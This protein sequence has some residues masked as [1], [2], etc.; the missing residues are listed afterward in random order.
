MEPTKEELLIVSEDTI[1]SKIYTIR[2]QKVM[3][4]ADLAEIYGYTTKA[5]NQQVKNNIEKFEA[6]FRF[7]LSDEETNNVSRSKNLTLNTTIGRGQNIKYNPYAFTEQGIYMLMTVLKGELA[8]KQSKSLIRIFKRM[9]DFLTD[10]QYLI[11]NEELLRLSLQTAQNTTDIALL[12]ENMIARS[13]LSKIM[14]NFNDPSIR[15][16]YLIYNGKTVEVTLAYQQIY[17][18][19]K[20]TV[21]IVDNYIGLKTLLPL[22]EV[23]AGV[24]CIVFSDN[25]QKGL[26]KAEYDDFVIEY[27]IISLSFHKTC[28]Q[29]HDRYIIIDYKTKSER[30]F[31][32]GTSS[33]DAGKR[34]TTI[35]QITDNLI[36]HPLIVTLLKILLL[37]YL[38]IIR[39]I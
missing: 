10:N 18:L 21:Y 27:P 28:N 16:E 8:I 6:D 3:L 19:A 12:K 31:H 36:Y 38:N 33:K 15:K 20:K 25:V 29:I 22:K 14:K 5:F 17:S 2:G 23:K 37:Y 9:K 39:I 11:G 35:T 34:V 7:Q 1:K 32:C 13:D 4:D 24:S 26:H 30:I